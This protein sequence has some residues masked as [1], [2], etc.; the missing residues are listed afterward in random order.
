MKESQ[1]V[2]EELRSPTRE[3]RQAIPDVWQAFGALHAS[4]LR[5]GALPARIKEL[6]ALAIAV[7]KQCDGCIASHARAAAREGATANE[8]AE[9]LG[10]SL[11]MGGGPASVYGPRAWA[12]Y[13]EF[14]SIEAHIP[15]DIAS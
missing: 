10:V 9:T 11:F 7:E 4:V 15:K 5:D 3:L 1:A 13:Q 8:V 6:I 2:L 14:V 12:A